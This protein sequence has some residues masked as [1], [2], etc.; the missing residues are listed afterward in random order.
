MSRRYVLAASFGML[1]CAAGIGANSAKADS[2]ADAIAT[3]AGC[4]GE[5]GVPADKTFPILHGQNRTYIL[6]QLHDFKNGRR[7]NEI[8]AG[9][10]AELSN[11]DMQALAT[12]FSKLKWPA[13]TPEPLTPD[14]KKAGQALLEQLNCGG[15]HHDHFT[16]DTVRPRLAGQNAEYLLKTLTEFRD[17]TR[18][19]FITM[20]AILNGLTDEELKSM[21]DY[22]ATLPSPAA[23]ATK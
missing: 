6:N 23:A 1:V 21:S 17:K 12:H 10:V 2:V 3:C 9:I 11:S 19:N 8:M 15:C 5:D 16:G 7:K 18:G 20:S 13:G 22:L 14:A 4:H